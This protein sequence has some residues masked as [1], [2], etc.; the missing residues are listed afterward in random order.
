MTLPSRGTTVGSQSR[1]QSFSGEQGRI[2]EE[3]IQNARWRFGRSQVT[4]AEGQSPSGAVPKCGGQSQRESR[5][6][7][8]RLEGTWKVFSREAQLRTAPAAVQRI[9]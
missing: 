6:P 2:A 9:S 4:A 5:R 3:T 8:C 7:L 1:T